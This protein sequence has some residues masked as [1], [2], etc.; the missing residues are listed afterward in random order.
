MANVYVYDAVA[1]VPM[2]YQISKLKCRILTKFSAQPLS[3][4]IVP[5]LNINKVQ[6]RLQFYYRRCNL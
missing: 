2:F 3:L 5:L 6:C 4:I 1:I